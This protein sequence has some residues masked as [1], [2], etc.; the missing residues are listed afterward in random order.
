MFDFLRAQ[1]R[2][3]RRHA[4]Y[5]PCETVREEGLRRIGGRMLDLSGDGAFVATDTID[6]AIGEE[7]FLAFK[8]PR[9]SQWVDARAIVS[10]RSRGRRKD[11][12]PMGLGL[13]FLEMGAVD[14][15]ILTA[16][17]TRL[18]PPIPTRYQSPDY[19]DFVRGLAFA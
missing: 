18:P 11:D 7:V 3:V 1:R 4:V 19:A 17:L 12:H 6:L 16:S 14:R 8:A 9:T 5:L 13:D 2:Y 15:A 10:R